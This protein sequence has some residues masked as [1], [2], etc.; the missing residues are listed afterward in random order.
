[1]N[2]YKDP[3][4]NRWSEIMKR[5]ECTTQELFQKVQS[6]ALDV[7]KNGD[8]A[9]NHFNSIFDGV[10]VENL[11]VQKEEFYMA[12]TQISPK[13]KKAIQLAKRNIEI[14]HKKQNIDYEAVET[15]SG[16]KCYQ[17]LLPIENVGLYIPG[18]N[19]PLISTVLMLAVPAKI[20]GCKNIIACTPAQNDGCINPAIVYTAKV[21]GINKI[22]K[23]GGIQAISAMAYGTESIP[24]VDKIFGP[25]NKYVTAA[26]QWIS[27]GNTAIDMPA[28]PSEVLVIANNTA[29]PAYIAA[30]LLSQ[31]EHDTQSLAI[32]L[33]DDSRV[34][35]EVKKEVDAQMKNLSRQEILKQSIKNCKLVKLSSMN[36]I[37]DFAN[38]FAPEHLII[39]TKNAVE[40]SK[41]I[42]NA[43]SVF[44]GDYSPESA[45]D[46]ASGTNHT[47][48]T[49]GFA[50]NYSG[51]ST[52]SFMKRIT[53]QEI[54]RAGLQ[55]LS[56][57]ITS[58]AEAEGL[59]AHKNAVKIRLN[60]KIKNT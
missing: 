57:T 9:V 48:P 33:T 1:M 23:C 6:I 11:D 45:G 24:K 29:K 8:S 51:L 42:V 53:Y 43:G 40:I 16:V 39:Q 14:F 15:I 60:Q 47:L 44:I 18:G 20:A 58:L 28:G 4:K 21:C 37:V 32:L 49:N 7:K 27:L 17:R 59:D 19:A 52:E 56:E 3:E 31:L 25:G 35:E 10:S 46:Y 36:K 26:K 13:L 30:D 34:I 5:P 22:F 2:I 38:E 41:Q 54:T 12:E 55:S 50:K